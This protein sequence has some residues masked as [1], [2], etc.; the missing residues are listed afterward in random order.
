LA[1]EIELDQ[2]E[3]VN[4]DSR[5]EGR[6]AHIVYLDILNQPNPVAACEQ[7]LLFFSTT[8]AWMTQPSGLTKVR[9]QA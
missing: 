7:F 2:I 8:V 6:M 1:E 9:S 5:S 4:D 3:I